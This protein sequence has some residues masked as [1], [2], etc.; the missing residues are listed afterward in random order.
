MPPSSLGHIR[1]LLC[2]ESASRQ[3]RASNDRSHCGQLEEGQGL[4]RQ[5]GAVRPGQSLPSSFQDEATGSGGL[6]VTDGGLIVYLAPPPSPH[7]PPKSS[8]PLPPMS[9]CS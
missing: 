3:V 4:A 5:M 2:L 7:K 6:P 9:G 1:L 8:S